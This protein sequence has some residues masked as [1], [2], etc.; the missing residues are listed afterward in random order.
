M[1]INISLASSNNNRNHRLVDLAI[2]AVTTWQAVAAWPSWVKRFEVINHGPDSLFITTEAEDGDAGSGGVEIKAGGAYS[3]PCGGSSDPF[4]LVRH[5][6]GSYT[7]G[8]ALFD[9][10]AF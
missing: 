8:L 5:A 6:S 10:E 1:A 2:G 7:F 4:V 3:A 9:G